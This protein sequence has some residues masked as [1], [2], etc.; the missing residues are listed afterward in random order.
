MQV[1]EHGPTLT[2]G[3]AG[4]MRRIQ[5]KTRVTNVSTL[6]AVEGLLERSPV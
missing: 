1:Q 3:L 6:R 5:R 4:L 2:Y